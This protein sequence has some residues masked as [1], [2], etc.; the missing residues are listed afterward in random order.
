MNINPKNSELVSVIT[1][2]EKTVDVSIDCDNINPKELRKLASK[3]IEC[4]EWM[5]GKKDY[6]TLE[7]FKNIVTNPYRVLF[8][9][10]RYE[11]DEDILKEIVQ[12]IEEGVSADMKADELTELNI[13]EY[14]AIVNDPEC[15]AWRNDFI[16]EMID[17]VE[18]PQPDND[19][20]T[21]RRLLYDYINLP[22]DGLEAL[23]NAYILIKNKNYKKIIA[24]YIEMWNNDKKPDLDGIG[25]IIHNLYVK[26]PAKV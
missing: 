10:L 18:E 17:R 5:D 26:Y 12:E 24:S 4:A 21:A 3:M 8:E 1:V 23:D 25:D 22:D 7:E 14:L 16:N 19:L 13:F 11:T 20:I 2:W 9:A 15:K 6:L